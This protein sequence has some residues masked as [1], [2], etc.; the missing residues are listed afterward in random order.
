MF[1]TLRKIPK[2]CLWETTP[3]A[4][5]ELIGMGQTHVNDFGLRYRVRLDTIYFVENWK[6]CSKIIFKCVNS[7]VR[8]IFKLLFFNKVVVGLMNSAWTVTLSLVQCNHV[9]EQY[10]L[11]FISAEK[12]KKRKRKTCKRINANA[13]PNCTLVLVVSY[14]QSFIFRLPFFIPNQTDS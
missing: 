13:D 4:H 10:Q 12:K 8:L 7:A 14:I 9:H 2:V 3:L 1:S 6:H 5:F 11:L